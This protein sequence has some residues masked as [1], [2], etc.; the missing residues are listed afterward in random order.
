MSL[1]VTPCNL[2]VTSQRTAPLALTIVRNSDLICRIFDHN[3][4]FYTGK[5]HLFFHHSTSTNKNRKLIVL[6][7]VFMISVLSFLLRNS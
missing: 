1:I 3:K 4:S 6:F 2:L 7:V 5:M